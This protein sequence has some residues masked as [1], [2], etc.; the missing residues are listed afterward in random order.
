[1]IF[2]ENLLALLVLALG[3]ALAVGNFLAL[4]R[5]RQAT[6]ESDGESEFLER[7]PLGRSLVM[8]AV[9]TIATIWALASLASGGEEPIEPAAPVASASAV[10]EP[11]LPH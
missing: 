2:G 6:E 11:N 9:G 1:M 4:V 5:P 3:A 8:I 7:P 10:F